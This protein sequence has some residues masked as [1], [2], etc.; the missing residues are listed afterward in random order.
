MCTTPW[1]ILLEVVSTVGDGF[2][3]G[4]LRNV[5]LAQMKRTAH[6]PPAPSS[7]LQVQPVL[8]GTG[9]AGPPPWD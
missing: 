6:Q 4:G 3:V 2:G 8:W 1:D 9:G 7:L 5:R